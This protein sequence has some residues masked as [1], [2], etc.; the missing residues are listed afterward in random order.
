MKKLLTTLF[1]VF[2]VVSAFATVNVETITPNVYYQ[3]ACE[4]VGTMKFIVAND[5]DYQ[6][7]T[8]Q[9]FILVKIQLTDGAT[10]CKNIFSDADGNPTWGILEVD[11]TYWVSG[12][13]KAY[14]AAGSD[15]IYI[16][17]CTAPNGT[18]NANDQAWF[19]IGNTQ[20][21]GT[22]GVV[23]DPN[24]ICVNFEGS[25]F[26][27]NEFFLVSITDWTVTADCA[28][29]TVDP[30]T[31][32]GSF[33]GTS[34]SPANPA[35][36]Y[37]LSS[38]DS[39]NLI[40]DM[41]C[42]KDGNLEAS[43]DVYLCQCQ[44]SET[45]TV[46]QNTVTT[47]ECHD[48]YRVGTL[49]LHDTECQVIL[50]ED[51]AGMLPV[52]S[53]IEF[54]VVDANGNPVGVYFANI[55]TLTTD[56][57]SG[58]TLSAGVGV[59]PITPEYSMGSNAT[60]TVGDCEDY[61]ECATDYTELYTTIQ[62]TVDA[63]STA[64]PGEIYLED[65]LLARLVSDGPVDA[66]IKVT[67]YP[68]PCGTGGSVII[69]HALKFVD[70]LTPGEYQP[71][72]YQA[73]LYFPYFPNAG[74]WWSGLAITNVNY[75]YDSIVPN[76]VDYWYN[77]N[78]ALGTD[79]DVNITLYLI[80]EDGDVYVYDAGTLPKSGIL[81]VLLS[82]SSFSPVLMNGYTD[83]AFGDEKF[84]VVAVGTATVGDTPIVLDG[85]GML[86]DGTQAQGFLPRI[87]R[88]NF[89]AWYFVYIAGSNTK[90]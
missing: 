28:D 7:A 1:A 42:G 52:D 49:N 15:T 79:Q 81:T 83:D 37:G 6:S 87:P 63:A 51:S 43:S 41:T 57:T 18:P 20:A 90:K 13:V 86:G 31:Y 35:V 69:P 58:L 45:D 12:D 53:I 22:S 82:D 32:V 72:F 84:W 75:Y 56:T 33:L 65:L 46:D 24:A 10:L 50:K 2:V 38:E 89:D 61:D 30:A 64:G 48:L 27:F 17:I 19:I 71:T 3:G 9:D 14:G 68:V 5:Q 85:F 26:S 40:Y 34:Y 73:S 29:D 47:Y 67:W 62:Y 39:H 74:Y 21:V 16:K 59:E 78:A 60:L 36:A 80:E 77:F 54:S 55:P 70:C 66:Y 8:S 88:W 25:S 11:G 76:V 4:R 23:F 44:T